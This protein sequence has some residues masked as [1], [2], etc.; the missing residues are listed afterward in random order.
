[1][2]KAKEMTCSGL[3]EGEK[4]RIISNKSSVVFEICCHIYQG[5]GAGSL[6]L[7]GRQ[8]LNKSVRDPLWLTK[9]VWI[10]LEFAHL[11]SE[12]YEDRNEEDRIEPDMLYNGFLI[13]IIWKLRTT[14]NRL[15]MVSSEKW[16]LKEMM[17]IILRLKVRL[18]SSGPEVG[19]DEEK[20]GYVSFP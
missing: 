15:F 11:M 8:C 17:I 4:M 19:W 5:Q 16:K 20:A 18:K 7:L 3:L 9:S 2:S 13:Q 6:T 10:G 1:M 12:R 14:G